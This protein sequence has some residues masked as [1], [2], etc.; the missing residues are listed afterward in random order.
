MKTWTHIALRVH[1]LFHITHKRKICFNSNKNECWDTILLI[2]R[3]IVFVLVF[4]SLLEQALRYTAFIFFSIFGKAVSSVIAKLVTQAARA[5]TAGT[6]WWEQKC[7]KSGTLREQIGRVHAAA[8]AVSTASADRLCK[9]QRQRA[10]S[11]PS[12]TFSIARRVP[13]RELGCARSKTPTAGRPIFRAPR[14]FI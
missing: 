7:A 10:S 6:G 12:R 5:Q 13:I 1:F 14:L 2:T 4:N 11:L 8:A 9:R 3:F